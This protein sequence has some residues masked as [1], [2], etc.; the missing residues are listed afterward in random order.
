ML[1]GLEQNVSNLFFSYP[2]NWDVRDN[3]LKK[4]AHL[5]TAAELKRRGITRYDAEIILA[6]GIE[7]PDPRNESGGGKSCTSKL[8]TRRSG[9]MSSHSVERATHKKHQGNSHSG[10]N[11]THSPQRPQN[12][13]SSTKINGKRLRAR[14]LKMSEQQ[15]GKKRC[16]RSSPVKEVTQRKVSRGDLSSGDEKVTSSTDVCEAMHCSDDSTGPCDTV[17]TE[18][19]TKVGDSIKTE[20]ITKTSDTVKEEVHQKSSDTVDTEMDKNLGEI[21]ESNKSD[22][23]KDSKT[24]KSKSRHLIK[25]KKLSPKLLSQKDRDQQPETS[26]P[27][28]CSERLKSLRPRCGIPESVLCWMNIPGKACRKPHQHMD[29]VFDLAHEKAFDPVEVKC[30]E[31]ETHSREKA[32]LPPSPP[33]SPPNRVLKFDNVFDSL[34][35]STG[36]HISTE[37]LPGES[38]SVA[39]NLGEKTNKNGG[40]DYPVKSVP[41]NIKQGNRSLDCPQSPQKQTQCSKI[42]TG[43]KEATVTADLVHRNQS[44]AECTNCNWTEEN[45]TSSGT[46]KNN[47]GEATN[48]ETDTM[49]RLSKEVVTE[50]SKPHI[51]QNVTKLSPHRLPSKTLGE[52]MPILELEAPVI[53]EADRLDKVV[54]GQQRLEESG[55]EMSEEED[56]KFLRDSCDTP[57]SSDSEI[58]FP[59]LKVQE[60][61]DYN[62]VDCKKRTSVLGE[63]CNNGQRR[64]HELQKTDKIEEFNLAL[65]K[66]MRSSRYSPVLSSKAA[67][68]GNRRDGGNIN[69]LSHLGDHS[70]SKDSINSFCS[71][72]NNNTV[73]KNVS[74]YQLIEGSNLKMRFKRLNTPK[75]LSDKES[76]GK[77]VSLDS[78]SCGNLTQQDSSQCSKNQKLNFCNQSNCNSCEVEIEENGNK[79]QTNNNLTS[80]EDFFH[81]KDI[82]QTN[83]KVPKLRLKLGHKPR[84]VVHE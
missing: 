43:H 32:E 26:S 45:C 16:L 36:K 27:V 82:S 40:S 4:Q 84:I 59:K 76:S 34:M 20:V 74:Q 35:A 49:P 61:A 46:P 50:R 9:S 37:D 77:T 73:L 71:S 70:T 10:R 18:V 72:R 31:S 28:R 78:R 7:L 38:P 22:V 3:N 55:S 13:T 17:K 12:A 23:F 66:V 83:R 51:S 63:M 5:L 54:E 60:D 81:R 65:Q 33:Q 62:V 47:S 75:E 69:S 8:R 14:Y 11:S 25:T 2:G 44:Q 1:S 42:P 58:S 15:G 21:E 80:L 6:Q 39:N 29:N 19:N 57:V 64:K 52:D 67:S 48:P 24:T 41:N 56:E 30:E 79:L 53:G 68:T